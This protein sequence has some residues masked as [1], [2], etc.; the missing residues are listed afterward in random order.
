M[1]KHS[2]H[3]VAGLCGLLLTLAFTVSA[4]A[5]MRSGNLMK[6]YDTVFGVNSKQR[7]TAYEVTL[8]DSTPLGNVLF[9]GEQPSFSFLVRNLTDQPLTVDANVS[10]LAYGTRGIPGDIWLPE[11]YKIADLPAIP[12]NINIEPK[13][14]Q[15]VTVSPALPEK[16][17]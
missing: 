14:S 16:F 8:F 4:S 15:V 10:V 7:N 5:Q 3:P 2:F 11:M 12:V 6:D 9:P 17:G 13:K 1:K